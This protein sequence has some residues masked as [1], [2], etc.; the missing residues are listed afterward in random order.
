MIDPDLT[1]RL[2]VKALA[3]RHNYPFPLRSNELILHKFQYASHVL[4]SLIRDQ[5]DNHLYVLFAGIVFDGDFL[6]EYK[7]V[8]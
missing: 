1:K 6:V 5:I 4:G 3:Y 2:S 8:G 7:L